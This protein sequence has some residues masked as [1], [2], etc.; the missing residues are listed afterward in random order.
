[1]TALTYA[2][3]RSINPRSQDLTTRTRA[4]VPTSDRARVE[5]L[6]VDPVAQ[7]EDLTPARKL[8]RGVV[9]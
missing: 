4:V 2:W 9:P 1:M 7:F 6:R 3:P 5:I 8:P